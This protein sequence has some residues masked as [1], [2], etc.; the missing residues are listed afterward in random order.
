MPNG[1]E[2]LVIVGAS[3][4][5]G[6]HL[7]DRAAQRPE[8]RIRLLTRQRPSAF[9]EEAGVEVVRGDLLE[10]ATLTGL[11]E[12]GC[13][14]VNLAYLAGGTAGD[15][16]AA[17]ANLAEACARQRVRRL[18]HCSTAVVV[19]RTGASV[20]DEQSACRPWD[21]Y[22]RTKL[23][24][25]ELLFSRAA[26]GFECVVLRPTAVF[27]AGGRNLRKLADEVAA[28]GRL[29]NYLKGCLY[30]RRRMNLVGVGQVVGAIL[31][32]AATTAEVDGEV[33]IVANDDTAM[34]NYLDLQ[35]FLMRELGAKPFP[36]PV[37]PLP[38]WVLALL[39]RLTGRPN[40]N[41]HRSYRS[42]RL[43][44][45]GCRKG[46]AFAEELAQFVAWYRRS[47]RPV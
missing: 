24:V 7:V 25:E 40:V 8:L 37:V 10:P 32:L 27:G 11:L 38:A 47:R 46:P 22:E 5:I 3:G 20:I 43:A 16:L 31:F 35:R 39:L 21:D 41:P 9:A 13:V 1:S 12:P 42:G 45:L 44:D 30:G 18:L 26:E 17:M 23:A 19:G 28:G 33:F 14:V 15:N 34:N 4:F 2:L 36:L 6:R 29:A